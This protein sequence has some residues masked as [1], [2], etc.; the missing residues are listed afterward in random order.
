MVSLQQSSDRPKRPTGGELPRDVF[1]FLGN[2][3]RTLH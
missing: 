1:P 3:F 2:E